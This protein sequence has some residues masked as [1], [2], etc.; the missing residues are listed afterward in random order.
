MS[1]CAS[2]SA[3]N[4]DLK[5]EVAEKRFRED[6]FFRLN[7]FPIE[8]PPLR[9][10][11]DDIPVLASLFLGHACARA[12]KSC[13]KISLADV[14][15]LQGYHWPGNIRELENVVERAVITA[16]DGRL[17]LHVP[18]TLGLKEGQEIGAHAPAHAKEMA[19]SS[20]VVT[21]AERRALEK[22]ALEDAL[23]ISR[24][25]V[26]GANGA[27]RLLGVKPTTLYSRLKRFGI[28]TRAYK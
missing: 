28:D 22:K 13:L 8:S 17:R 1:T 2:I 14:E 19:M 7:V 5:V 9:E 12:N 16:T 26:A 4:R 11:L 18:Q 15:R 23:R 10:R 25:K 3:T 24:G 21:E 6:L 20:G 27:G